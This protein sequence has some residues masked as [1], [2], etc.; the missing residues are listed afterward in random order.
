LLAD[1]PAWM[2]A[3]EAETIWIS[4]IAM[5]MP[6]TIAKKAMT[7]RVVTTRSPGM[8]DAAGALVGTGT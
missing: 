2:S 1:K 3:S 8:P 6:K 7:S 5:N 4:R